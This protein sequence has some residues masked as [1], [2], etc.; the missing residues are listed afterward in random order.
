MLATWIPNNAIDDS[1][2][3]REGETD[4][5]YDYFM[6]KPTNDC[7]HICLKQ[8][9]SANFN[10]FNRSIP[11]IACPPPHMAFQIKNNSSWIII[12]Y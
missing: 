12:N 10:K 6:A 11:G 4:L 2:R 5:A 7:V 3:E 8:P 1:E 9:E